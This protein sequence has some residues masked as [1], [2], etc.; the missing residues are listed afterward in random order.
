MQSLI[1]AIVGFFSFIIGKPWQLLVDLYAWLKQLITETLP[2]IFY[3]MLPDG[4]A[5]YLQTFDFTT[6]QS[7][8]EPITWFIPF[9]LILNIYFI[10]YSLAALIRM[11]RFLIGFIPAIEG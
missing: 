3:G 9:W 6:L 4:L 8:I 7:M 10:A 5:A 1:D 2:D 11:L